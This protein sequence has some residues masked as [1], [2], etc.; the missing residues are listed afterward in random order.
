MIRRA[1]LLDEQQLDALTLAH[2]TRAERRDRAIVETLYGSGI[3]VSE[4]CALDVG[5]LD[6]DGA[7]ANVLGKGGKRRAVPLS[8]AAVGAL[9]DCI[10]GRGAG[11][12]FL[13]PDGSRLTSRLA[14]EIVARRAAR[15]GLPHA[16]PHTLRH[17]CA[18]H[19]LRR[20]AYLFTVQ[21]LLGH[22]HPQT[23]AVYLHRMPVDRSALDDYRAAHPRA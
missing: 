21:D 19:M 10:A 8:R 2:A 3:R 1:K 15:A 11:A 7:A 16:S 18:S 23:T 13:R 5:D 9:R 6:L 14:R 12:V 20:G 4:M 17:S 22:A